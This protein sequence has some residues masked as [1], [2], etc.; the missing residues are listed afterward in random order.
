M[1][2][3]AMRRPDGI[4]LALLFFLPLGL[5]AVGC[6]SMGGGRAAM[7]PEVQTITSIGDRPLPVINGPP[8]DA[9]VAGQVESPRRTREDGRISGRVVD[10]QGRP[11]ANARVRIAVG[12]ASGGRVNRATTEPDGGFT[13]HGLRPGANYTVIAE[14]DEAL[15]VAT[16]R[17]QVQAPDTQARICLNGLEDPPTISAGARVDRV[18]NRAVAEEPEGGWD[19]VQEP[20][21]ADAE[22]ESAREPDRRA[23]RLNEED[24]PPS[25][26]E[27]DPRGESDFS[28]SSMPGPS[29]LAQGSQWRRGN[30]SVDAASTEAGRAE[31]GGLPTIDRDPNAANPSTASGSG[32]I[33]FEDDGPNP[34]PPAIEPG[35]SRTASRPG[36]VREAEPEPAAGGDEAASRSEPGLGAGEPAMPEPARPQSRAKSKSR[37]APQPRPEP[38]REPLPST[39]LP[40]DEPS[41]GF[42]PLADAQ[43]PTIPIDAVETSA[44]RFDPAGPVDEPGPTVAAPSLESTNQEPVS[45]AIVEAFAKPVEP[46]PEAAGLQGLASS[47]FEAGAPN[48]HP[49]FAFPPEPTPQAPPEESSPEP[50]PSPSIEPG[51]ET[52]EPTEAP[53]LKGDVSESPAA[54]EGGEL[55]PLAADPP[56]SRP[57]WGEVAALHSTIDPGPADGLAATTAGL[58][59]GAEAKSPTDAPRDRVRPASARSSDNDRPRFLSRLIG[60]EGKGGK[61]VSCRYDPKLRQIVDFRLPDLQGEPVRFQ[62]L[63]ADLVLLDFWGTWCSFCIESIPHMAELQRQY[64]PKLRVVGI[65]YENGPTADHA[66]KVA[67]SAREHGIN[68]TVLLGG[69]EGPCPLQTALHVQAYPTLVLVDRAGRILWRDTGNTEATLARLDR[70]IESTAKAETARR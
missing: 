66:G 65:A 69:T 45:A 4:R 41:V 29:G 39:G 35:G 57:S 51:S 50:S 12:G 52:L 1:S 54:T 63:D 43:A 44:G 23:A 19:T 24:L 6:S 68:Y 11:V 49:P 25:A 14:A 15:G 16:G 26:D 20:L 40:L 22:F 37:G 13:L 59:P 56:A 27:I 47:P 17:V 21:P 58:R 2:F 18:S 48:E 38:E 70:V 33:A 42:D 53:M 60:D 9:I 30:P 64:G 8:G 34:L 28:R 3:R 5:T 32:P 7:M 31:V 55:Q 36:S 61:V 46:T 10:V 62:D 67:A